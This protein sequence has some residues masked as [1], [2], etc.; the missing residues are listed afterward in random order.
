MVLPVAT[1]AFES[2]VASNVQISNIR[3][4]IDVRYHQ[5]KLGIHCIGL[6][7]LALLV[8]RLKEVRYKKKQFPTAVIESKAIRRKRKIERSGKF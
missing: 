7:R 6:T 4:H 2:S 5:E 3:G 1:R 8:L